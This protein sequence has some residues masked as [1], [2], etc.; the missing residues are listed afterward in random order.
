MKGAGMRFP[1][2]LDPHAAECTFPDVSLALSDPNGLLAVGGNLGPACL[3]Q[4]YRH[5]I[6]PWYEAGQPIL[7][8]SPD[9]RMVLFP[10]S[11]RVSRSL[12]KVIR[13]QRFRVSFDRAFE[14]VIRA[15]SA[16]RDED[17]PGTWITEEMISAYIRLH[18]L[19]YAHSVETWQ[20]D[21]LVGGVYGIGLGRVFF[22]ESMFHQRSDASKVALVHLVRR[23]EAWGCAVIDCQMETPHLA[24]MG[25]ETIDRREFTGLLS[26]CDQP[27]IPA[28]WRDGA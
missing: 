18:D 11:L 9:P 13:Q 16:P 23:L 24:S 25:A 21:E 27:G 15:C 2:L 20:D 1:V 6:F 17:H 26:R 28:C 19:G 8:W 4:A 7:W 3:L 12:R 5:G 10:S 22:G 14:A